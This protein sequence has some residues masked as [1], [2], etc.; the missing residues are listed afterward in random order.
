MTT[1]YTNT[2]DILK[3]NNIDPFA[4]DIVI[5]VN[6]AVSKPLSDEEYNFLCGFVSACMH[7]YSIESTQLLVDIVVDLYCGEGYGYRD[8]GCTLTKEDLQK[9]DWEKRE[10]IIN[11]YYSI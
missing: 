4:A 10:E 5:A 2:R 3:K 9:C 6:W 7:D 11:I 8:E 1:L